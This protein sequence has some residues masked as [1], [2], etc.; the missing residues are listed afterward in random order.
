MN[1]QRATVRDLIGIEGRLAGGP[2]AGGVVDS[3]YA[4]PDAKRFQLN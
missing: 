2:A 4:G 1:R 3:G